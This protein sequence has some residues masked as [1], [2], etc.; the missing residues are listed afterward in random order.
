MKIILLLGSLAVANAYFNIKIEDS[1]PL[2]PRI[3][4]SQVNNI[5]ESPLVQDEAVT[6]N[7]ESNGALS[8]DPAAAPS[9]PG[10]AAPTTVGAL[11]YKYLAIKLFLLSLINAMFIFIVFVEKR[12][13]VV[14]SALVEGR[15]E[16]LSN[17]YTP[18]YCRCINK[19]YCF[20][21]NYQRERVQRAVNTVIMKYDVILLS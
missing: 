1:S 5:P 16:D 8:D 7:P 19:Y 10:G 4:D 11:Y 2:W 17:G 13:P 15:A 9:V 21:A 3:N 6:E 12:P 18:G 14:G 20:G